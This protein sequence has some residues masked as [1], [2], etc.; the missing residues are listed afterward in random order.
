MF[1]NPLKPVSP[2]RVRIYV[3]EWP[4]R[5]SHWVI[6]I[7]ILILSIT[8]YY[9]HDP[10]IVA[11]GETAY[12][13]GTMRFIHLLSAFA[14]ILAIVL[15]IVWFFIGN[16]W[17]N[18]RNF[19]PIG[20]KRWKKLAS[21]GKYYAFMKW[22][23]DSYIGHNPLAGAAYAVVY[24]LGVV[25]IFTG[26]ALYAEILHSR[27][28]DFFIGWLPRLIDIQWLREIHFLIMFVFWM[29]LM[30]HLYTAILISVE[31]KSGLMDS[32]FSGYKFV[33]EEQVRK[34]ASEL[35]V[36]VPHEL[37]EAPAAV[38]QDLPTTV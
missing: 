6:A 16:E 31:E 37:K 24:G 14:F 2:G 33:P 9:M 30:H 36:E 28:L 32:I 3:W 20:T 23:P 17:A 29:F 26:L 13:M 11:R 25:E 8:G 27:F 38:K 4:V 12:V 35:K 15:R 5:C 22:R 18:W 34:E 21:V 10:Y 7:T 19:I 1:G